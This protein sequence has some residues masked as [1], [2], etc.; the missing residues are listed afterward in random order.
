MSSSKNL[1]CK[2]LRLPVNF[3]WYN[4]ILSG[5][6]TFDYR[7]QT[8]YWNKRLENKTYNFVEFFIRY[9]KD[10]KPLKYK[11]IKIQSHVLRNYDIHLI[12]FGERVE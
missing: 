10:V 2:V 4:R 7:V 12:Y 8:P 1:D 6:L 3:D 5:E 11:F 9:R